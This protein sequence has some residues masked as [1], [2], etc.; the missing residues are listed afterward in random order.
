MGRVL[1]FVLWM[2]FSSAFA[3]MEAVRVEAIFPTASRSG[4]QVQ[5]LGSSSGLKVTGAKLELEFRGPD[6]TDNRQAFIEGPPGIYR[7]DR[8][9][10]EGD[11]TFKVID[12]TFTSEALEREIVAALPRPNGQ[13]VQI[14]DWPATPGLGSA[15]GSALPG[16]PPANQGFPVLVVALL[17]I[18][19]LLAVMGFSLLMLT[20]RSRTTSES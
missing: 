20:R 7:V 13:D 9:F 18:P 19:V 3:H 6:G 14:W 10:Q 4:I 16:T 5:L 17:G 11:Y 2:L 15:S 1:V 8:G 12:K